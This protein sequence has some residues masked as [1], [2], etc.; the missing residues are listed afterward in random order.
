MNKICKVRPTKCP[1]CIAGDKNYDIPYDC[2]KC[3]ANQAVYELISVGHSED[4][5]DWAMVL[6][7]SAIRRVAL[8]RVTD[9]QTD[10]HA[11]SLPTSLT[12]VLL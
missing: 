8:D 7:D 6:K 5:G 1:T 3:E 10:Y 4:V 11:Y 12:T 2:D 9:V